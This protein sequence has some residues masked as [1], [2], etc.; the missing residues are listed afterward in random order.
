MTSI[1]PWNQKTLLLV[2]VVMCIHLFTEENLTTDEWIKWRDWQTELSRN[3]IDFSVLYFRKKTISTFFRFSLFI[4]LI[5]SCYPVRRGRNID[6]TLTCME[7]ILYSL[8]I[9]RNKNGKVYT[10]SY[11]KKRDEEALSWMSLRNPLACKVPLDSAGCP[12]FLVLAGCIELKSWPRLHST[13]TGENAARRYV[14]IGVYRDRFQIF[15][16][17]RTNTKGRKD[18]RAWM[19]NRKKQNRHARR[20]HH[21]TLLLLG[22]RF[23]TLRFHSSIRIH[24]V[25]YIRMYIRK[26]TTI[27]F[28]IFVFSPLLSRESPARESCDFVFVP[29]HAL[30]FL[31]YFRFFFFLS[32]SCSAIR[33]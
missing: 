23:E 22:S 13:H 3:P 32:P 25:Y 26:P 27:S 5:P 29:K 28:H 31:F 11:S 7:D 14:L 33:M 21:R 1:T 20:H 15:A 2:S 24:A 10:V 30:L 8:T 4:F 12:I 19:K 17:T 16:N 6:T 18:R 9:K